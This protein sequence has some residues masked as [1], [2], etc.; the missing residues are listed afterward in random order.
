[1]A[2][3]GFTFVLQNEWQ[4]VQRVVAGIGV[5]FAPLESMIREHFLPSLIG[6]PACKIDGDYH[7]L[8]SHSVKTGGLA[9]RN[10]LE[11]AEYVRDTSSFL[12]YRGHTLPFQGDNVPQ[13]LPF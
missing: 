5:L 6:I 7:T 11:R 4:Y 13:G 9:V 3:A 10:P 2:Y 8:L 12:R 1:M